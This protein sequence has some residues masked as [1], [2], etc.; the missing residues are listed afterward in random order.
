MYLKPKLLSSAIL[1]SLLLTPFAVLAEEPVDT[2]KMT[3]TGILP[4]RLEAVPGSFDLIDEAELEQRRPFSIKEALEE[5]P[6]INVVAEDVFSTHLNIGVRG[7]DPRRSARTLLMEDGMPLYLAPYGD[8]SAHYSTPLDRVERIEV[9]KGSGQILYG[10]QTVGGMINF[11]TKPVPTDGI[12]GSIST[13]I[14]NNN[15]RGLH[16]NVGIG[17]EAGGIMLDVLEKTG[18][19]VRDNHELDIK[20]YTLKGQLNLTERQTLIAKYSYFEEDSNISETM[21]SAEDYARDKFQAPTGNLDRFEQERETFQLRHIF[22][23]NDRATLSTQAYYVDN[24]RASFRQIAGPNEAERADGRATIEYC[25]EGEDALIAT[26]ANAPGCGGRWRPRYFEYW[27]VEARMDVSHNL[28]GLENDAVFGIRYHE[29]DIE[30]NQFRGFSPLFQSRSYAEG[31]KGVL[32]ADSPEAWHNEFI[33][34][35]VET[36]SYYLQNTFYAGDWAFTPGVRVEDIKIKTNFRISEGLEQN[37]PESVDTYSTT[38]VLPGFGVAWNGI[39]NT[40]I[41][42]GVHKGFAPAR[43]AREIEAEDPNSVDA[44]QLGTDPEESWNYELGFRSQFFTGINV[45]STLFYTDFEEIVLGIDDAQF[46]NAGETEQ[47]GL[48]IAGRVDFGTIF[49]MPYNIYLAGSYTNV[50]LAEHKND[51]PRIG[52]E[53]FAK[54]NRLQYSP[55]HM[56]NIA[57]GYEN[58]RGFDARISVNYVS[59]QYSDGLNTNFESWGTEDSGTTGKIPSYTLVNLTANYRPVGTDVTLFASVYNLAD[60]EYLASRVDGKVA[61]RTRQFFGGIRYDF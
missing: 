32:E 28:F 11:V 51:D 45:Q 8:P 5:V 41:F 22:D 14:G 35:E 40:T 50:F 26:E 53:E 58:N 39:P 46:I 15:F 33:E 7:L 6:G 24:E 43:P 61:G 29:E 59:E 34:T 49:D 4:D 44:S 17:G 12:E 54:G 9:V 13:V 10:P 57:L 55:R 23:F 60:R 16:G 3:V 19:G 47:A 48:E 21:L 42:A 37:N 38:E 25:P 36:L 30:R 2:G 31:F 20:E 18:D 27:G 52:D 1:S 56:A